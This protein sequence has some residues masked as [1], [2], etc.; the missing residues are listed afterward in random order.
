[1]KNLTAVIITFFIVGCGVGGFAIGRQTAPE[2]WQNERKALLETQWEL[3]K[4]VRSMRETV[5][6][7]EKAEAAK[8]LARLTTTRA[9]R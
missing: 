1:M 4:Q 8:S 5:M 3:A 7:Y 2:P 9:V 6:G